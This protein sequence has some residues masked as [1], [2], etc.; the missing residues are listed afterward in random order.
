MCPGGPAKILRTALRQ[1]RIALILLHMTIFASAPPEKSRGKSL[2]VQYGC[3][4][5]APGEWTNFDSS[6]TLR[7]E[8]LPVLGRYTKNSQRFPGNVEFGD[9]VKGLPVPDESCRGLYASHVL[10]HL[11]PHDFHKA[12]HNTYRILL[13]SGAFRLV[14][15]DLE[16]CARDY[17][18]RLDRG[19]RDANSQFLRDTN[20][21]CER[22]AR[23]LLGAA[24]RLF[25][26]LDPHLWMWDE[27][28]LKSSLKDHGFQQ[29][30]RCQFGD[31]EDA[32]FSFVEN[33]DRFE[34]A[35][36][37]EARR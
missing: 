28:S 30:R 24:K 23:G 19:D 17:I 35:I 9:I 22:P 34:N 27:V 7:W 10:E 2:Y 29:I 3:G 25:N 21:G 14:L 37:I 5:S 1:S 6:M 15:P 11:T 32:M 8:R 18:A 31:S 4:W 16:R 26:T 33:P 12:L 13:K 36:A 20:L